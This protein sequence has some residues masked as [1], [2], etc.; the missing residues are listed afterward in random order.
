MCGIAG[1]LHLRNGQLNRMLRSL[2]HRGPDGHGHFTA[3]P[4]TAG[5][6]RLAILDPAHG[7]QPFTSPCGRVQAVCNGEIYNWQDLRRDLE[8]LG[9]TFHTRCDCEILPAAWLQWREHMLEKINGMFAIALHD[10]ETGKLLLARDRCGQKPLYLTTTGPLLFASEI[11][12]LHHAGTD[13]TPDPSPLSQWLSLRYVEEPATM[14][15]NI[16]TLPAAHWMSIDAN[17]NRHLQRY[18]Q[19]PTPEK[20]PPRPQPLPQAVHT[21]DQL[22]RSSVKLALQSDVPVAAYLSAGV[23]SSLLAH[24]IRDLGADITTLSIGFGAGSDETTAATRFAESLGLKHHPTQLTPASL[25][26]LPRVIAQ[27][28][29]PVGDALILAFDKLASHTTALGCK[30]ALGGEG[31]DEHF[32]GY[33]FQKAYLTAHKLGKPGRHLAAAALKHCPPTWL[34]KLSQFPADLGPEGRQKTIHYLTHFHTLTPTAQTTALRTLFSTQDIPPLL[35]PD[36]LAQQP[37]PG[38]P[39]PY[40]ATENR[41]HFALAPQYTSW[42]PDWSLIRQDK[43]TMAHSLEYRAP[44]LDHRIIDFA[45]T[46][47]DTYKIHRRTDKYIWR[48]LAQRHLPPHVTQRTKQPF[49]LP[50]E[51]PAWRTPLIAMAHDILSTTGYT[52]SGWLNPKAVRPLLNATHFLPLK[53]LAAILILQIWLQQTTHHNSGL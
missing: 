41:L 37:Q 1:G 5:M 38:N 53:Q 8:A 4:F 15:R 22:T 45:F 23:D 14:F 51:T 48:K 30:V 29:R 40:P 50:L 27:M 52:C 28:E 21:L 39:E 47:P 33:S 7:T 19:P 2:H 26:D 46:L 12:A 13:L 42:L 32:A 17:G 34:N 16:Q 35:H 36:I 11:R 18:W 20:K 49:Y 43:N 6:T 24:Y 44:F 3:G 10:Q 9:H 31:P 25:Q